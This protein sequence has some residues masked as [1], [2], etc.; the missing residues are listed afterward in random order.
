MCVF[1]GDGQIVFANPES[2][3]LFKTNSEK[4]L[5]GMHVFNFLLPENRAIV[6]ERIRKTIEEG[7]KSESRVTQMVRPD[8]EK[9][10]VEVT[11]IPMVFQRQ[12]SVLAVIRDITQQKKSQDSLR[13][14]EARFRKLV[15][16]LPEA[17]FAQM[18]GKIFYYNAAGVQLM[19]ASKVE[20]LVGKSNLDRVHPRYHGLMTN[21]WKIVQAG[22]SSTNFINLKFIRLDG[23]ELDVEAKSVSVTLD[24]KLTVLTLLRDV[25]DQQK[26]QEN[27]IQY[28]RQ[29]ASLKVISR[30]AKDLEG[31]LAVLGVMADGLKNKIKAGNEYAGELR[32]LAA[33]AKSLSLFADEILE[34]SRELPVNRKKIDV[35]GLLEKILPLVQ[36]QMGRE[37][38]QT[39]WEWEESMPECWGDPPRMEQML[40]N[41]LSNSLLAVPEDGILTIKGSVNEGWLGIVLQKTSAPVPEKEEELLFE[42]R[43]EPRKPVSGLAM[44][45]SREIAE[46][47]GGKIEVNRA[48]SAGTILTLRIPVEGHR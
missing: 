48:S 32:T 39:C 40:W 33:Q 14:S 45:V 1:Q 7:V 8:G 19:G 17:V 47:Y 41:M 29:A 36:S 11:G 6:T 23:R 4:D 34:F 16:L 38:I 46:A 13:E 24:G 26:I 31:P 44:A 15:D 22:G 21:Q 9:I 35:R 20:D 25:S 12:N 5:I 37:K 2:A 27:L 30:L 43:P 18:D 28:E 10:D 42:S 3:R